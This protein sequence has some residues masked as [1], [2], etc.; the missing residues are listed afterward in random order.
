M[1]LVVVVVAAFSSAVFCTPISF[2]RVTK[3]IPPSML[4]P[5]RYAKVRSLNTEGGRTEEN[6]WRVKLCRLFNILLGVLKKTTYFEIHHGL[7][8]LHYIQEIEDRK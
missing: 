4:L 3:D 6:I 7:I 5:V 2:A 8:V 1:D